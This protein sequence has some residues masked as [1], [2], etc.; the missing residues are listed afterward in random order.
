M[1]SN[2]GGLEDSE[3]P[4]WTRE[5]RFIQGRTYITTVD[6]LFKREIFQDLLENLNL[7]N[8]TTDNFY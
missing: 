2:G 1:V 4:F 3:D 6:D 5:G 7:R 8:F